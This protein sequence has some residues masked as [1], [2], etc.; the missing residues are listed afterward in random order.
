M[1][2]DCFS[3][4]RLFQHVEEATRGYAILDLIFSNIFQQV[5]NVKIGPPIG[6][7][8]H[9]SVWFEVHFEGKE[10]PNNQQETFSFLWNKMDDVGVQVCLEMLNWPLLFADANDCHL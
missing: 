5:K 4:R 2:L 9:N 8:D 1:F 3:K 6:T 10:H 7:S